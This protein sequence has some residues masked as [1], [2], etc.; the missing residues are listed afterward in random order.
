MEWGTFTRRWIG[1]VV[2]GLLWAVPA[3][4]QTPGCV[5]GALLNPAAYVASL[6]VGYAPAQWPA[7]MV[8]MKPRLAQYGI[9]VQHGSGGNLRPRIFLPTH[10]PPFVPDGDFGHTVDIIQTDSNG[11]PIAWQYLDYGGG[12]VPYPC[13]SAPPPP[14]PPPPPDLT[15]ILRRLDALEAHTSALQTQVDEV[16]QEAESRLDAVEPRVTALEA[17]P[18]PTTCHA[19]IAGF[20]IH[21]SLP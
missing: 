12:Y 7:A 14:P 8:A 9:D 11:V 13:D 15:A 6:E 4:A 19:S 17:R 10:P 18:I 1:G 3:Q 5:N 20:P 2:L 21:C 16:E